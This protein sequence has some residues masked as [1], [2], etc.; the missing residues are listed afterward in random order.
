MYY[1][2]LAR[3]FPQEEI[4]QFFFVLSVVGIISLFSDIGL[5]AGTILRFVLFYVVQRKFNYVK[6]VLKISISGSK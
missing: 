6:K 2:I 3:T 5:R 4:G 1:I